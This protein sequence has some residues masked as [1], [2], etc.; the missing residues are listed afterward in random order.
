MELSTK[1]EIEKAIGGLFFMIINTV[2]W[3]L[4]AEYYLENKDNRIVGFLIG[5]VIL[6][7]LFFYV[8]FTKFHKTLSDSVAENKT[9]EEDKKD[10][11]FLWIF[12][13][14]GLGIFLAKNILMNLN[15]NE[16]FIPFFALIVGLH[17][18]PLGKLFKR[19]FDYYMGIWTS[20][21]A[22]IGLYVII[23]KIA[24][25]NLANAIISICCA[26]STIC[27]GVKMILSGQKAITNKVKS[28]N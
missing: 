16:L 26:I 4:I 19:K 13:L 15:H 9:D 6:G 12:G 25:V 23:Q 20:T 24:T 1:K 11:R 5:I 2:I 22:I 7:F 21:V 3:T 14:E 27:Y 8:R 28:Q 17:F 10:K 18:F